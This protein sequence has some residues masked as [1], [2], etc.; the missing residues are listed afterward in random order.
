MRLYDKD[1][2]I[3]P[4]NSYREPV[5]QT[6]LGKNN[7]FIVS[8]CKNNFY[9]N[10]YELWENSKLTD[11]FFGIHLDNI[12]MSFSNTW[13]ETGGAKL[14]GKLKNFFEFKIFKFLSANMEEGY[15][16]FIASDAWTQKKLASTTPI[17]VSLKFKS[18]LNNEN[19][20]TNYIDIIKFLTKVCSPPMHVEIGSTA[21]GNLKSTF[22]GAVEMGSDLIDQSLTLFDD[23]SVSDGILNVATFGENIVNATD[24]IYENIESMGMGG[25]S[26]GNFTV[27][28]EIHDKIHKT[29]HNNQLIDWFISGFTFTPSTQFVMVDEKPKPIYMDFEVNLTTRLALSNYVVAKMITNNVNLIKNELDE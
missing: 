1:K 15:R 23:M 19:L 9:N 16:P 14:F 12:S 3:T 24:N 27:V 26:N 13:A 29:Y 2:L 8:I 18:Y 4:R 17:S 21:V 20:S 28:L 7:G 25:G 10:N 6:L 22:M 11:S 5:H